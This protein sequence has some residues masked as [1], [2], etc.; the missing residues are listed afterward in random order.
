MT[1]VEMTAIIATGILCV[2]CI[3]CILSVIRNERQTHENSE[4]IKDMEKSLSSFGDS[5][6]EQTEQLIEHMEKQPAE[7]NE[8]RFELLEEEIRQLSRLKEEAVAAAET[9]AVAEVTGD[10]EEFGEIEELDDEIELDDLFLQLN[11][12]EAEEPQE[13]SPQIPVEPTP[14]PAT[15]AEQPVPVESVVQPVP[16]TPAAQPAAATP[17]AQPVPATPLPAAPESAK[18]EPRKPSRYHQG[19]NIGRSGRKY[20]AEELNLLIRE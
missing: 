5:I 2:L 15:P 6:K 1:M 13:V 18:E 16:A 12:M 20:T 11:A 9:L 3:I 14:M 17:A 4:A 19:Y 7:T 10:I 8:R